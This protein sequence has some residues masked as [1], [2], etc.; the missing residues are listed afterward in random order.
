MTQSARTPLRVTRSFQLVSKPSSNSATGCLHL[1]FGADSKWSPLSPL[2]V[3]FQRTV[4]YP[5][6]DGSAPE[7]QVPA[8]PG[9][10]DAVDGNSAQRQRTPASSTE[11]VLP[12]LLSPR[13]KIA[14]SPSPLHF[15]S[16]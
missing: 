5:A 14:M 12:G 16:E 10:D 7:G 4:R 6:L 2:S 8:Q 13:K 9:T 15:Q 3:C 1:G 11:T